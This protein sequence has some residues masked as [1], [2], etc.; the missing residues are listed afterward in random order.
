MELSS[1][2]P[3][4]SLNIRPDQRLAP[5][6]LP[7]GVATTFAPG[8]HVSGVSGKA[9]GQRLCV[10]NRCAESDESD[11]EYFDA[12][13]F[14]ASLTSSDD[15]YFEAPD[16]PAQQQTPE[17]Q[18]SDGDGPWQVVRRRR[19]GRKRQ[20]SSAV[21]PIDTQ[22]KNGAR[23]KSKSAGQ[24]PENCSPMRQ[25]KIRLE[26]SGTLSQYWP[27]CIKSF[28]QLGAVDWASFDACQMKYRF[29]LQTNITR[30]DFQ[31]FHRMMI[32][33]P[34]ATW[35]VDDVVFLVKPFKVMLS[36]PEVSAVTVFLSLVFD[37]IVPGFLIMLG[38]RLVYSLTGVKCTPLKLF[39][40][41]TELLVQIC[42]EDKAWLNRLGW[43]K[44]SLRIRCKLFS[45]VAFLFKQSNEQDL[46][47]SL[48]QQVSGS[49]LEKHYYATVQ[50]ISCDTVRS[51]PEVDLRDLL[52][53]V[54]A[55]F[56]W[57][58]A[59]FFSVGKPLEQPE[60][61]VRYA[62]ICDALLVTM[63]SLELLPDALEFSLWR[64]VAQWS[65]RFRMYLSRDL[66]FDRAI[67]LLDKMLKKI[68]RWPDLDPLAFELRVSLL[69][70]V[71]TKCEE[72]M[73]RR[74]AV[75]PSQAWH[76]YEKKLELLL[77]ECNRFMADYRPPFFTDDDSNYA[78][79]EKEAR[80]NLKIKES[81]FNR[82]SCEI[83]RSTRQ[84]IQENLLE[85]HTAFKS[86][87][88]LSEAF[89][90]IGSIE[91]AKWYF[92]AGE[93]DAGVSTLMNV[94][95][96]KIKL[97]GKKADLLARH[98]EY[99]SAVAELHHI[100]VLMRESGETDRRKQ[101]QV[102]DRIAMTQ[103]QWYLAEDGTDHLI[104]AYRLSVDLLGRC[105]VRDRENFEGVLSHIV[106]AMKHSGLRF[107]NFAGQTSVLGYL[108]KEGSHIK[109]WFH[110]A[111]LLHIRHKLSLT[112]AS[113]ASKM[114]DEMG[115]KHGYLPGLKKI[116]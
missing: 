64:A 44:L 94:H 82:L 23:A 105:D 67:S 66:G 29:C 13:E 47:R 28:E 88:A 99:H 31:R 104:E 75:L 11:T 98:G 81:V 27:L 37:R 49:W 65:L 103:L 56:S 76:E 12:H 116:S 34:H 113:S 40:A 14:A 58:E 54:R 38:D 72:L 83:C 90:E 70:S 2:Q 45:S 60:L 35:E 18:Q 89:Q 84:C 53:N 25:Q 1:L 10:V 20:Q 106:N 30:D 87:W 43:Q 115:V 71:L 8:Q 110:L 80:L 86:G 3:V 78:R 33:G 32:K 100:K 16:R 52:A 48:H 39:R 7:F 74:N 79:L 102:D 21:T 96:K 69:G 111:N 68:D 57:L 108:V 55:V 41:I 51:N 24:W 5:A 95:C 97:S 22:R 62:D 6:D 77:A 42:H 63:D 15:E 19:P 59:Q 9:I 109:S 73:L 61:I 26:M 114:A 107:E 85:Y 101:D 46:I 36:E 91:L 4:H 50:K 92:L 112:S 93:Y 17:P